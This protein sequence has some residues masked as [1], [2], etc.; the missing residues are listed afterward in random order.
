MIE[1][2]FDVRSMRESAYR[3]QS[4]NAI[5]EPRRRIEDC[6]DVVLIGGGRR[7]PARWRLAGSWDRKS[8]ETARFRSGSGK[9]V[10]RGRRTS[11]FAHYTLV[12]E[13]GTG[14]SS[15][16]IF[17][18]QIRFRDDP[19]VWQLYRS[20]GTLGESAVTAAPRLAWK[21]TRADP[22]LPRG[23]FAPPLPQ[24]IVQNWR[25][26]AQ[27]GFRMVLRDS[28]KTQALAVRTEEALCSLMKSRRDHVM[29]GS[30]GGLRPMTNA[31]IGALSCLFQPVTS[32]LWK[33]WL[34]AATLSIS[35]A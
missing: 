5:R 11:S 24:M 14:T 15:D 27:D 6:P 23:I 8:G 30:K 21:G 17:V 28:R 7:R 4:G 1:V 16:G 22:D 18:G 31:L 26:E 33:G 10:G 34:V 20:E 32:R 3:D 29:S 2:C 12:L 13:A 25:P 35:I 9:L 19:C